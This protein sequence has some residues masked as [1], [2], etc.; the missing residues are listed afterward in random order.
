MSAWQCMPRAPALTTPL[1]CPLPALQ[2]GEDYKTFWE[3]FGKFIRFGVVEDTENRDRLSKLLRF[4]SSASESDLTSLQVR[5]S[6]SEWLLHAI[7]M[8]C[9]ARCWQAAGPKLLSWPLPVMDLC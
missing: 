6:G 8:A 9:M 2:G 4:P 1:L 7:V 3:S 5:G